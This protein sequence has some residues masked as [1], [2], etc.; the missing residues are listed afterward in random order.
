MEFAAAGFE[1]HTL[2]ERIGATFLF[3]GT[4]QCYSISIQIIAA[5]AVRQSIKVEALRPVRGDG[6]KEV[7]QWPFSRERLLR[8]EGPRSASGLCGPGESER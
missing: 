8:T 3:E 2:L 1:V 6:R 7:A 4:D 5:G